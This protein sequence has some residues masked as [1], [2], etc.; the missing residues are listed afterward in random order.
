MKTPSCIGAGA[1]KS[2]H[3]DC[4]MDE[5]ASLTVGSTFKYHLPTEDQ[6]IPLQT[7]ITSD[8][9]APPSGPT[10]RRLCARFSN[11][12][13]VQVPKAETQTPGS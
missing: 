3:S 11:L 5:S 7:L 6:S 1:L 4:I 8:S 12:H 10:G 9:E 13:Q 2:Y